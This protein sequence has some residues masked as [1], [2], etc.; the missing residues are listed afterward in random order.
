MVISTT[1]GTS[2]AEGKSLVA[3]KYRAE[4]SNEIGRGLMDNIFDGTGARTV[5][6]AVL[7]GDDFGG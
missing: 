5:R 3:G 2:F 7:G 4:L 1:T 6:N